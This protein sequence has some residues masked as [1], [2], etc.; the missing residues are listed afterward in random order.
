[1][2]AQLKVLNLEISCLKKKYSILGYYLW[3]IL[4]QKFKMVIKYCKEPFIRGG[5]QVSLDIVQECTYL[6]TQISSTGNFNAPLDS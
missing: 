6:V 1:M 2:A 5:L 3:L 4:L